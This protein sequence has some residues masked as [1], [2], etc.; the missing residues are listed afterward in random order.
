MSDSRKSTKGLSYRW[1]L[2][3]VM[4]RKNIRFA[5]DLHRRLVANGCS[6]SRQTVNE[7]VQD[8]KNVRFQHIVILCKVLDC[9]PSDLIVEENIAG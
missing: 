4:A 3:E 6:V 9:T 8:G 1:G 5:L 7:W 2:T